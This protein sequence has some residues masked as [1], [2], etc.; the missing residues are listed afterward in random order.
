MSILTQLQN[1]KGTV[2]SALG[3]SLAKDV[4]KGNTGILSEAVQLVTSDSK[5]V[6]SG[7]AKI[8][9][10]VAEERP[11]MVTDYLVDLIPAL[12]FPE[13]QTRWMITHT[14]GLCAKLKPETAIEIFDKAVSFTGI[15]HGT[16][17][18]DSAIRY[19]G[20]IGS[21]SEKHASKVFPVLED[22]I[23]NIPK[24]IPRILESFNRMIECMTIE[25]RLKLSDY[26]I[27]FMNHEQPVVRKWAVKIKKKLNIKYN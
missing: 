5:N 10:C 13:P 11:D 16:C 9:E 1:N 15:N 21:L 25:D 12:E 26:I 18:Q 4:L 6:R 14:L 20:Y 22:A 3:K 2:S 24:R 8:I 19:F 7:A 27:S 23:H 17:L